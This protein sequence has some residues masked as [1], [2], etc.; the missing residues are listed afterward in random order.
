MFLLTSSKQ[1]FLQIFFNPTGSVKTEFTA[2]TVFSIFFLAKKKKIGP[3]VNSFVAEPL[4]KKK[5]RKK[6]CLEEVKR[7]ILKK[8]GVPENFF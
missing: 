3:T 7:N 8:T 1:C 4:D 2:R 6:H 5:N